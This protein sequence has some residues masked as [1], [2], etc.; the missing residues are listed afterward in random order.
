MKTTWKVVIGI[1]VVLIAIRIAL[2][3]WIEHKINTELHKLD[4]YDG[5]VEDVDLSFLT[6]HYMVEGI[7]IHKIGQD[8]LPP[9]V[10][11]KEIDV[12]VDWSNLF[13]GKIVSTIA[14]V[15][16]EIF[17]IAPLE[18]KP[19]EAEKEEKKTNWGKKLQDM[20]PLRI[21]RFELI[22]GKV[23]YLDYAPSP[24]ID[25]TLDSLNIIA[26]NLTNIKN[27]NDTFP[28]KGH[29]AAITTGNGHLDIKADMNILNKIPDVKANIRFRRADLT[30]FNDFVEAY[31]NFDLERGYLSVYSEV[32][33]VD[34]YIKGYVKPF[35]DN[36][37]IINWK[38]DKEE[39]G[40]FQAVWESIAGLF[41]ESSENQPREQTASK[42]PFGGQMDKANVDVSRSIFNL[43]RHA[44][45]Q[46]F[47]TEIDNQISVQGEK[48]DRII[49]KSHEQME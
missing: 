28:A 19:K 6:G 5:H 15:E 37:E 48:T 29:L 12:G 38:K 10:Q 11:V 46:A 39:G 22:D 16:P 49:L 4:E 34:G 14:I 36:V 21:N 2:P 9:F 35:F 24:D 7:E 18:K 13:K 42:V 25:F 27:P 43:L 1:L 23:T 31:G 33:A 3:F 44:F 47:E 45:I 40:F 20:T 17:Y 41:A 30:A 26:E 8:S 32:S